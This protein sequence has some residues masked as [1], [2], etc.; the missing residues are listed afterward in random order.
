MGI[1]GVSFIDDVPAATSGLESADTGNGDAN[2]TTE[3]STSV[4]FVAARRT[5]LHRLPK[6]PAAN[7]SGAAAKPRDVHGA[8]ACPVRKDQHPMRRL[9]GA[10][11]KRNLAGSGP[12]IDAVHAFHVEATAELFQKLRDYAVVFL[13]GESASAVEDHTARADEPRGAF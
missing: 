5:P 7:R 1:W 3:G 6:K 2:K 10:L 4:G 13:L 8:I 9:I 11:R 12:S